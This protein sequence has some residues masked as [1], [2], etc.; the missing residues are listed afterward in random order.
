MRKIIDNCHKKAT[1]I[2]KQNRDLLKLIAEALLEYE[3]LTKEQIDELV[4]K[5]KLETTAY[6]VT[7]SKEDK[8]Q[9]KFKLVREGNYKLKSTLTVSKEK[10][11]IIDLTK[12]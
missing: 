3:T 1:E 2:I 7:D 12:E 10:L 6:S 9:P 11:P 4:E 8:K 5:G